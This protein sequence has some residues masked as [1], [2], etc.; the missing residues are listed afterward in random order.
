MPNAGNPGHLNSV[1][2]H[3]VAEILAS[4]PAVILEGPRG[5]G[6]M[7]RS[8]IRR[9]RVVPRRIRSSTHRRR[10]RLRLDPRGRGVRLLGEWQLIRGIWNPM[11]H[12]CGQRGGFGHFLLTGLQNPPGD[13]T[14]HSGRARKSV[15]LLVP[16]ERGTGGRRSTTSTSSGHRFPQ[17]LPTPAS[18]RGRHRMLARVNDVDETHDDHVRS[19]VNAVLELRSLAD[20]GCRNQTR[21]S[22]EVLQA[23][24]YK[25]LKYS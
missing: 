3:E 17:S 12:A 25:S 6:K 22:I 15:R 2:G 20:H 14:E 1:V 19:A 7:D 10:G 24:R 4:S 13:I 5:C 8:E 16:S 9:Q 23:I 18:D 21:L 11:R